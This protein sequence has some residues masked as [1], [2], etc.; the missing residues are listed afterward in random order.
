MGPGLTCIQRS[1]AARSSAERAA[2]LAAAK[3]SAMKP[4]S[5]SALPVLYAPSHAR[6]ARA[7]SL[8]SGR[9]AS[10]GAGDLPAHAITSAPAAA[11]AA[12]LVPHLATRTPRS[13]AAE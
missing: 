2:R 12:A 4:R 3:C 13:A 8:V 9:G 11:T 10:V 5:E 1:L 6:N 7:A